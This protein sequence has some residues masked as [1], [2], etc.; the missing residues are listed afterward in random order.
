MLGHLNYLEACDACHI[1][2]D[3][4]IYHLSYTHLSSGLLGCI[5]LNV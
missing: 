5:K 3:L 4:D 2:G 1:S